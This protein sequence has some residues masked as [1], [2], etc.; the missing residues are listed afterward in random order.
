MDSFIWT[1]S[2]K[3]LRCGYHTRERGSKSHG[4]RPMW[5]KYKFMSKF[6]FLFALYS[7]KCHHESHI[8][9][10]QIFNVFINFIRNHP[11]RA[12]LCLN[13]I[14]RFQ[15]DGQEEVYLPEFGSNTIEVE[16]RKY[17]FGWA[18]MVSWMCKIHVINTRWV[19]L[20]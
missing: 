1:R 13:A 20:Y 8:R 5:T 10:H 7:R 12:V 15:V 16:S 6:D 14:P 4:V 17:L 19:N 18:K 9:C 11:N 3:W 2:L